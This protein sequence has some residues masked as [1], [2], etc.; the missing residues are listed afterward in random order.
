MY[1]RWPESFRGIDFCRLQP[2]G[3]ENRFNEP[4]FAT[5]QEMAAAIADVVEP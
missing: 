5:Y 1:R 2:P 3:R 4:V